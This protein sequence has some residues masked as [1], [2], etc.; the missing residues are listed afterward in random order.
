VASVLGL[1]LV[2]S[3]AVV[4]TYC[5]ND[6]PLPVWGKPGTNQERTFLAC[7]PDAVQRGLVGV[8]I[9]RFEARGKWM[10][11][12]IYICTMYI[13]ILLLYQCIM[14]GHASL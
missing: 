8:I 11:I 1:A 2:G 13:L 7:K 9:A 10:H 5:E 3:G 4:M 6:G 12:Y 14:Q